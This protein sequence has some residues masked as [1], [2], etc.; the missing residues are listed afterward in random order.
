[1]KTKY[2]NADYNEKGVT[3]DIGMPASG[4]AES[5]TKA[6]V[7]EGT[8]EIR[9]KE[10]QKQALAGLNRD[11]NNSLNKLGEIFY[12]TKMEERQELAN[13]FGEL[14]YNEIHKLAKKNGWEDGDP[15]KDALHALVGS[16][17]SE[18]TG[19]G[20]L[21]GASASAVNEMVQKK[22]SEQFEGEPDKHQWASAIIGGIVSQI[23]AGNALAGASTAASG[24][25]N[26]Y[27]HGFM[28]NMINKI[29]VDELEENKAYAILINGAYGPGGVT[30]GCYV[31][32]DPNNPKD[33]I[34]YDTTAVSLQ[35][36]NKGRGVG[37]TMVEV[38]F[39]S[40][41]NAV[42]KIEGWSVSGSID[43]A[44]I[45]VGASWSASGEQISSEA[46]LSSEFKAAI[47]AGLSNTI[48]I[49]NRSDKNIWISYD[50][51]ISKYLHDNPNGNYSIVYNEDKTKMKVVRKNNG[52]NE[53]LTNIGNKPVWIPIK[54]NSIPF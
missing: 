40:G 14:A 20:F 34:I 29:D 39:G 27:W 50:E 4:E 25:K 19:N 5:I 16:I 45:H 23:V 31:V 54:S 12:K 2:N 18:L 17:M 44:S 28:E 53:M 38:D 41:E 3:L 48:K 22:L 36:L 43:F 51:V 42:D 35:P 37:F 1:M 33:L 11:T 24:T 8:I 47:A 7:S 30:V 13:L 49:G 52:Y 26:N 15:E 9:D 32:K 10:N 6:T 46:G 21:A